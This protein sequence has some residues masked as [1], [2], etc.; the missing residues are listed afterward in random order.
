MK[1]QA[2]S[3]D[4]HTK[5]ELK[6]LR[7]K[8]FV[9]GSISCKENPAVSIMVDEKQ[10]LQLVNTHAHEIIEI[11]SPELGVHSV[12]L[13][14]VQRDKLMSNRLLHV[15]FH[16]INM[17]EPIKTFIRL[18]FVGE[19][20]GMKEGGMRQIVM[21]ELEIK[22]LP[23]QLPTSIQVDIS[24]LAIGDKIVVGDIPM[25]VGV[26]CLS[27]ETAVVVTVL[28]VQS[29]SEEAETVMTEEAEG[30]GLKEKSGVKIQST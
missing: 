7:N 28:H 15:D 13:R 26:E 20:I 25:P 4:T 3:R 18:E 27:E 24:H 5:S 29:V 23:E 21:N 9:P 14:E 8:G 1:I 30:E 10:L 6:Q 17:N 2:V 22:V 11:Q 12:V 16:E 19:A